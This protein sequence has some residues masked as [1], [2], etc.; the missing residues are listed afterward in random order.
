MSLVDCLVAAIAGADTSGPFQMFLSQINGA[1]DCLSSQEPGPQQASD[2]DLH[3][4]L[5]S[6]FG[7]ILNGGRLTVVTGNSQGFATT[8]ISELRWNWRWIA[9]SKVWIGSV[10]N[11]SRFAYSPLPDN[12][13][14]SSGDSYGFTMSYLYPIMCAGRLACNKPSLLWIEMS[15]NATTGAVTTTY[16]KKSV[17]SWLTLDQYV[18]GG[19]DGSASHFPLVYPWGGP[20]STVP[21]PD[22]A[23]CTTPC[24][25][26]LLAPDPAENFTRRFISVGGIK[27]Y[28]DLTSSDTCA[29][30][31]ALLR[32][33]CSSEVKPGPKP[34][35]NNS[36]TFAAF[37]D[38]QPPGWYLGC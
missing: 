38:M 8:N 3:T 27:Y 34:S 1:F 19:Y 9:D 14:G 25:P 35:I 28:A 13:S 21:P 37:G 17:G 2:P 22:S 29:E 31:A 12:P 20:T 4:N 7:D 11:Y 10:Y 26:F 24:V 32:A 36:S 23:W 18:S 5:T 30:S 15:R 16:M 33:V 6:N